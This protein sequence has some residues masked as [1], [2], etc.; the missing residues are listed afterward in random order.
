MCA[1][2]DTKALPAAG[3]GKGNMFYAWWLLTNT[4]VIDIFIWQEERTASKCQVCNEL[5]S[6]NGLHWKGGLHTW[7][8]RPQWVG[9]GVSKKQT[10]RTKSADL[11][12]WHRGLERGGHK[13]QKFCGHHIWNPQMRK[14]CTDVQE[15][16]KARL[17]L[18][19]LH[20][21]SLA[22]DLQKLAQPG[23][24]AISPWANFINMCL[25]GRDH[26]VPSGRHITRNCFGK[27]HSQSCCSWPLHLPFHFELASQV[28]VLLDTATCPSFT[29]D[30][31]AVWWFLC[32]LVKAQNMS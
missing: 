1:G 22:P 10:K 11:W 18:S 19:R 24:P 5:L 16:A 23:A 30:T 28:L 21:M 12:Q 6:R 7:R 32:Y 14:T 4:I 15:K 26:L 9:E 13:I 29:C 20:A 8:L 25:S 17:C 27:E 3:I 2:A 31:L